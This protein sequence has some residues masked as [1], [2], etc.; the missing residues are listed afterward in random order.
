M[1]EHRFWITRRALEACPHK[2][3]INKKIFPSFPTY[4]FSRKKTKKNQ[5]K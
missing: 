2:L 1:L 3:N 4:F 5:K